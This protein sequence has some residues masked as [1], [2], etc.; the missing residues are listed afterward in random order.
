VDNNPR[1]EGKK[2]GNLSVVVLADHGLG[3]GAKHFS[4]WATHGSAALLITTFPTEAGI[5][6]TTLDTSI[7]GQNQVKP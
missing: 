7:R 6:A 3:R 5:S 2:L 1:G 4:L